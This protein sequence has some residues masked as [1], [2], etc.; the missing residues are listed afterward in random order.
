MCWSASVQPLS[1]IILSE[2]LPSQETDGGVLI[3]YI[4]LQ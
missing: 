3:N 1:P 2:F 4:L